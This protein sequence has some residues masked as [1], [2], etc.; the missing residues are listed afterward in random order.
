MSAEVDEIREVIQAALIES[1][2]MGNPGISRGFIAAARAVASAQGP[3]DAAAINAVD[4]ADDA[5]RFDP[6]ATLNA[7]VGNH[8]F[9]RDGSAE[10][11]ATPASRWDLLPQQAMRRRATLRFH[12]MNR[13]IC[14]LEFISNIINCC[15]P[16]I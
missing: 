6:T 5:L 2:T 14:L 9:S 16:S 1:M 4:A 3:R 8:Y 15:A 13:R 10:E 7:I 12:I 11:Q